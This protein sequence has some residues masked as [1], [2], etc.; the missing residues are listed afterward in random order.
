VITATAVDAVGNQ[1]VQAVSI[2]VQVPPRVLPCEPC[3]TAKELQVA[4]EAAREGDWVMIPS[5]ASVPGPV[6]VPAGISLIGGN[7]EAWPDALPG[8]GATITGDGTGP[9]ITIDGSL[10]SANSALTTTLADL[11]ITGGAAEY[12]GGV[13]VTGGATAVIAGNAIVTNSA[14]LNGGAVAVADHSTVTLDGNWIED[15]DNPDGSAV[16]VDSTS[17]LLAVNNLILR[18]AAGA[19]EAALGAHLT[20]Y[21][22]DLLW[23][24]VGLVSAG[25]TTVTNNI[26]YANA[27]AGLA[28][29]AGRL[30]ADYNNLAQNAPDRSGIVAG[31]HDQTAPPQW[32][33][34]YRLTSTAPQVNAGDP[35]VGLPHDAA[36]LVRPIEALPDLGA[37]EYGNNLVHRVFLALIFRNY[38]PGRDVYEPDNSAAQAKAIQLGDVQ[39]RS[40][41]PAQDVDWAR[42]EVSPGTYYLNTSGLTPAT[43]TVLRLY[44]AG[45]A[46]LLAQNDDCSPTT[47]AS[48]LTW[49]VATSSTLYLQVAPY[50]ANSVG[51]D[52]WYDLAI[53][54]Q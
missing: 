10:P 22:N 24:Y 31:T 1:V 54:K 19:V 15:N 36:G 7:V 3:T 34:G 21:H 45:G 44:G 27:G 35:G 47:R 42:F 51:A 33:S 20:A 43:D 52:R 14:T 30:T 13:L 4:I 32:G 48:C 38:D 12:G 16:Y 28:R 25:T 6:T 40:F 53:V 39:H 18:N 5:G 50:D 9:V 49:T 37:Y 46:T 23:N 8:D 26:I 2:T 41:Y 17:R 11:T 29:L